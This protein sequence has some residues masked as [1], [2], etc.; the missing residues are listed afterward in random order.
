MDTTALR[1]EEF[2]EPVNRQVW[3]RPRLLRFAMA[4]AEFLNGPGI[5]GVNQ[6]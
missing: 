1:A 6:S 2:G 3:T 4:R 5:D